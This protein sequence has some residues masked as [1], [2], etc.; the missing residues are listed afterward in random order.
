[1]RTK[2][3]SI[4]AALTTRMAKKSPTINANAS[5]QHR[6]IWVAPSIIKRS[7]VLAEKPPLK[8]LPPLPQKPAKIRLAE[9]DGKH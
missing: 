5:L 4:A 2:P 1:M 6:P 7:N 3:R 8:V 9:S